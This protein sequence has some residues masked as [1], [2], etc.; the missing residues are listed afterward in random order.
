MNLSDSIFEEFEKFLKDEHSVLAPASKSKRSKSSK[1][2]NSSK[3]SKRALRVGF[4]EP[5]PIGAARRRF[6]IYKN[7]I[8][9]R[10][11]LVNRKQYVWDGG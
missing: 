9:G 7:E 1:H 5:P 11:K 6:P 3:S 8:Y 4:L 2:P 10:R